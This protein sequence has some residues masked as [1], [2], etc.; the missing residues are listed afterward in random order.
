[1]RNNRGRTLARA[2]SESRLCDRAHLFRAARA[3]DRPSSAARDGRHQRARPQG[4]IAKVQG[5]LGHANIA[6]TRAARC[7]PRT[8][9]RSRLT[10][11]KVDPKRLRPRYLLQML[12][13]A[14]NKTLARIMHLSGG[15]RASNPIGADV[16]VLPSSN[17][18]P[19]TLHLERF[20]D[21]PSVL[22]QARL[23]TLGIEFRED[24]DQEAELF[25]P[26]W[27]PLHGAH[28]YLVD[29]CFTHW[30]ALANGATQIDDYELFALTA[31]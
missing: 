31:L 19:V 15:I 12:H 7:G 5:S 22:S 4:D 10:T 30:R 14:G 6:T 20:P 25:P 28:E 13:S 9:R 24:A 3:R 2:S 11:E 18:T 8:A 27:R 16:I 29:N 23:K 21:L 26:N 17:T 1:M